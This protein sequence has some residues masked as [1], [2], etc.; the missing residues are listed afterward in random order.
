MTTIAWLH[1]SDWHEGR[2]D[3]DR[4]RIREAMIVDIK[5]RDRLHPRFKTIDFVVFSGDI[6]NTAS[7]LEYDN[8]RKGF[9]SELS[10][11]LELKENF[12]GRL[13]ACPGN[14]DLDRGELSEGLVKYK[15]LHDHVISGTSDERRRF[16]NAFL[17]KSS[18][19]N[20][21]LEPFRNYKEFNRHYMS[22]DAQA[23]FDAAYY[24]VH[25]LEIPPDDASRRPTRIAV[26]CMNS[27]WLS[28]RI[29]HPRDDGEY[30]DYGHLVVGDPQLSEV[31]KRLSENRLEN[32]DLRIAVFHHPITWLDDIDSESTEETILGEF[33]F[34]L[35]GHQHSP[36]VNVIESTAGGCVMIPAG[37]CYSR[38]LP[39]NPRH[40]S[41][42]NF[43]RLDLDSGMGEVYFRR[44]AETP[45]PG[46]FRSD[47][48]IW[49]RGIYPF[50]LPNKMIY[51]DVARRQALQHLVAKRQTALKRRVYE[52]VDVRWTHKWTEVGEL[53]LIEVVICGRLIIQPGEPETVRIKTDGSLRVMR[54]FKSLGIKKKSVSVER[55]VQTTPKVGGEMVKH[56]HTAQTTET[57][58]D[59][60]PD[61]TIIDYEYKILE[62]PDGIF[63]H[64]MDRSAQHLRIS[65]EKAA[66]LQYEEISLGGLSRAEIG[67]NPN[68]REWFDWISPGQGFLLRW[69]PEQLTSAIQP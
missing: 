27:A 37:A 64:N 29:K 11:A 34:L 43:V 25:R 47:E 26:A 15:F 13:F 3:F 22:D 51:N 19:R 6:A 46:K 8:V 20:I 49:S 31:R 36:R 54:I 55:V 69:Y 58:V 40:I 48:S 9:L 23:E 1:I 52:S 2:T 10:K 66:G 14:H 61:K 44:W 39:S 41:S 21:L 4:D 56:L 53:K 28:A 17:S 50:N 62:M 24:V 32:I 35:T 7:P 65:V 18:D 45:A 68:E 60:G 59:I 57:T 16:I 67:L 63:I 42:Y 30:L 38:R 5:D 33:H 12:S